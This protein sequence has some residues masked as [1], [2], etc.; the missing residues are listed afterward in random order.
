MEYGGTR[1]R[2]GEQL[3][4]VKR[5]ADLDAFHVKTLRSPTSESQSHV[6]VGMGVTAPAQFHMGDVLLDYR[7]LHLQHKKKWC[8]SFCRCE[9]HKIWV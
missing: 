2:S 4:G 7:T 8:V 3:Q 9:A 1:F 5:G 6:R